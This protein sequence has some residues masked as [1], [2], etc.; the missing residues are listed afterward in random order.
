VGKYYV[1]PV[2]ACVGTSAV[3]TGVGLGVGL[4]MG[5]GLGLL[6]TADTPL[7][8]MLG[9]TFRPGRINIHDRRY[10]SSLSEP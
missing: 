6:C 8:S 5:L 4:G 2:G 7:C 10:F 9:V 3:I 1:G